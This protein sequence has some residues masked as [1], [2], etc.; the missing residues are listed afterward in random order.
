MLPTASGTETIPGPVFEGWNIGA[1]TVKRVR[2]HTGN[3]K[4]TDV[5]RHGG[6]PARVIREMLSCGGMPPAGGVVTGAQASSFLSLPYLP[7]SICIEIALDHLDLHPDLVVCLGGETFVIYCIAEGKVRRVMSSN[8][9]AAGSGEFLV[10][11]F[12]RMNM[13]V[14]SGFAA[15][16]HGK[17]VPLASRCSVHCK[18]DATH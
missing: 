10:Q 13:D 17:A 9:C 6:D 3:R 12:Q 2:L 11:Q 18:S 8:R 5:R 1:V 7:E 15:A 14:A 4:E 16:R